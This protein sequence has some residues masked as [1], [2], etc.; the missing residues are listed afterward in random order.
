MVPSSLILMDRIIDPLKCSIDPVISCN[1]AFISLHKK[2]TNNNF[3]FDN[4]TSS[5]LS[6]NNLIEFN[7]NKKHR[8]VKKTIHTIIIEYAARSSHLSDA[9]KSGSLRQDST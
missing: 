7:S 6:L 3:S 1:G 8:K 2:S 4:A 9:M 5:L